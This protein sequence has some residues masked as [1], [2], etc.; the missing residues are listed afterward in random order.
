MVVT[1]KVNGL[2]HHLT[3]ARAWRGRAWTTYANKALLMPN[4]ADYAAN[5]ESS[6]CYQG[7]NL[8]ERSHFGGD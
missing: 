7:F 4:L 1:F 2:V 3:E 5:L 6:M 8:S